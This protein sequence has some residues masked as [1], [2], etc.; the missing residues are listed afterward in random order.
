MATNGDTTW[1]LQL[2]LLVFSNAK[3]VESEDNMNQAEKRLS[4][5]LLSNAKSSLL[6][7]CCL[8]SPRYHSKWYKWSYWIYRPLKALFTCK[9]IH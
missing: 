7:A 2:V 4:H 9:F 5:P 8:W 1:G 3:S 6:Q